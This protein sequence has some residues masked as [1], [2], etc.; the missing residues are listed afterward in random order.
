MFY[1]INKHEGR[2]RERYQKKAGLSLRDT[3]MSIFSVVGCLQ[4]L[5][6]LVDRPILVS[7]GLI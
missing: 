2:K 6:L 5:R 7:V 4:M 3:V 1:T